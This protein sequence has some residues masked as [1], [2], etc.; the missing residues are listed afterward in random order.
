MCPKSQYLPFAKIARILN[1]AKRGHR[2][3]V[4]LTFYADESFNDNHCF[5]FGGWLAYDDAWRS[6]GSQWEKRFAYERRKHGKL[7]RYHATDCNGGYKE[8]KN[9]TKPERDLHTKKLLKIIT[10]KK[11]EMLAICFGLDRK[12]LREHL[13][14]GGDD[15]PTAYNLAV[16]KV[17]MKIYRAVHRQEGDRVTIIHSDAPGYNGVIREAFDTMMNDPAY[18]H[19]RKVFTTITPLAWQDCIQLQ[20]ADLIAFEGFKLVDAN[21]RT[22]TPKMR[23]SFQALVGKNVGVAVH[24]FGEPSIA[25]LGAI[26]KAN[27]A[28]RSV[29]ESTLKG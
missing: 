5:C 17:M 28:K 10:R 27:R 13:A 29:A 16:R 22:T 6:I 7:N 1:P 18:V 4:L 23:R 11:K 19:Y 26:A 25:K 2:Y 3:F 20:P 21:L 15:L 12:A 8:Y 24:Y 9:W 14:D